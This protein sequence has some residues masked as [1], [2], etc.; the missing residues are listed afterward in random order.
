MAVFVFIL[1]LIF[2]SFGNVIVSRINTGES[3]IFGGSRCFF[4]GRNLKWFELAPVISFLAFHGK[5]RTCGGRVSW[6]YPLVELSSGL[7]FLLIW[8]E[9]GSGQAGHNPVLTGLAILFFWLLLIISVYDLRHKIIPNPLVYLAIA[10]A[11]IFNILN[12]LYFILSGLGLFSFF[13]LLWLVS[14]GRWM[15]FGDAKLALAMGLFLGW[16]ESAV[17]LLFS[18]WLGAIFGLAFVFAKNLKN[19]KVQIPFAPFLFT[20]GLA[21]FLWGEKIISWYISLI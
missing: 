9:P 16:P 4:C 17:A 19:L 20:G 11:V 21:A 5:C 15:G 8:S 6:R 12:P 3:L 13:A 1:G 14:K 10:I 7:L 2:G 18:F